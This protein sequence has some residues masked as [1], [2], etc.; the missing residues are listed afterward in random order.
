MVNLQLPMPGEVHQL[1]QAPAPAPQ[2]VRPDSGEPK[3]AMGPLGFIA[4]AVF[5]VV[6]NLIK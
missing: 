2:Q 4:V 6:H 5:L 3:P 1:D